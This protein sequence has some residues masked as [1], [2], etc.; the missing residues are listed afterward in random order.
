M[1]RDAYYSF[2]CIACG[3]PVTVELELTSAGSSGSYFEPPEAAEWEQR[4]LASSCEC[5]AN[6]PHDYLELH[7]GAAMNE[8]AQRADMEPNDY[9]EDDY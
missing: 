1:P 6:Y 3:D 9:Y 7:H 4:Y 5:G 8:I 2:P